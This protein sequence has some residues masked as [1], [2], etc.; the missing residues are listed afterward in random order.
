M[1]IQEIQI[2]R[3]RHMTEFRQLAITLTRDEDRARDLLQEVNYLVFKH[4]RSFKSGTNF[5]AWVKA[6]I[7]NTFISDYR[8][9]KRRRE[10]V[11][12]DQPVGPWFGNHVV[13]NPAES[14][15]GVEEIMALISTLPDDY[16][17]T[18]LL[19]LQG[20]K[21]REIAQIMQV[22]V[23]TA[24]SRVYAARTQLKAQLRARGVTRG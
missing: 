9:R 5:V 20:N 24:K 22:P 4:R 8:Q 15:M 13:S 19:H 21:Y 7:R 3:N 18:F 16:R 1:T 6:I 17:R 2:L 11:L 10:L 12:R 23:G 14:R